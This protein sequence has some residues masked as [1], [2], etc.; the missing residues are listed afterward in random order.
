MSERPH[1]L[2]VIGCGQWGPNHVRVFNNLPGVSVKWAIDV[3][4]ERRRDMASRFSDLRV[5][6]SYEDALA[7]H[8]VDAV[9]VA[10][11][12]ASHRDIALAAIRMGKHVLCEK[13]LCQ[14][15]AQCGELVAAASAARLTLMVGHVFLFN[16]AIIRL[17]ETLDAGTLGRIQYASAVR[18]NP[19]PIRADVNAAWDLAAHEIAIFNYLFD[20]QPQTV[21]ARGRAIHRPGISD[22]I[23]L[24][25]TY[26][27]DILCGVMVS[28][29][30]PRK[31]RQLSIV[32]ESRMAVFDDMSA[33]PLALQD[34]TGGLDVSYSAVPDDEPLQ[35]QARSFIEALGTGDA[36]RASGLRGW[37]VVDTLEAISTS[38]GLGGAPTEVLSPATCLA[39][40]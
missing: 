27:S 7:D 30:H 23:F 37:Q 3:C 26:P 1:T 2:A 19:G 24:A 32:G 13:P 5:S 38:I 33:S 6:A 34:V 12:V 16:P 4:E 18:T 36:G 8:E 21:S 15:S 20:A 35:A 29:L 25:L 11:P 39:S 17:K 31:M 22:V 40:A 28:W 9:V 10:T 14:S